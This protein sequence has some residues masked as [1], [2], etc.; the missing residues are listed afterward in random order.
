MHNEYFRVFNMWPRRWDA[1]L[2][3]VVVLFAFSAAVTAE[4]L[5]L[6]T[7]NPAPSLPYESTSIEQDNLYDTARKLLGDGKEDLPLAACKALRSDS[8]APWEL[9][10]WATLREIQLL[11]YTRQ[12][13]AALDLGE[14]WLR[15]NPTN[16]G[17][18]EIRVIMGQLVAQRLHSGFMPTL[19]EVDRVF[20]AIF[21]NHDPASWYVVMARIEY[22]Q[23]LKQF[24]SVDSTAAERS[25]EQLHIA[26]QCLEKLAIDEALSAKT[27]MEADTILQDRVLPMLLRGDRSGVDGQDREPSPDTTQLLQ[28]I[29][30]SATISQDGTEEK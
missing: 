20:T 30:Q 24:S 16:P 4:Q 2:S 14:A 7:F 6:G 15:Q 22:A 11:T 10:R 8:S 17:S 9:R 27:R 3:L 13:R 1:S 25:V 21:S 5:S 29:E 19:Q 23:K 18:L 12:E 26:R 28:I